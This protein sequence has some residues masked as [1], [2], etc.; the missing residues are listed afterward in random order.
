M[1]IKIKSTALSSAT[2]WA[3]IHTWLG[4]AGQTMMIMILKMMRAWPTKIASSGKFWVDDDDDDGDE[5]IIFSTDIG[6]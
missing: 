3:N 6:H 2:V 5:H 4:C 1:M